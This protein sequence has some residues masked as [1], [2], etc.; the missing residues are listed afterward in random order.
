MKCSFVFARQIL[1]SLFLNSIRASVEA[2]KQRGQ[3]RIDPISVFI[4]KS[5]IELSIKISDMGGGI[6]RGEDVF[7]YQRPHGHGPEEPKEGLRLAAARKHARYL[8]G[9]LSLASMTGLATDALLHL[10]TDTD[11]AREHF[12]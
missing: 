10:R 8:G 12:P 9:D 11:L 1:H 4:V 6:E 2:A 5:P 3:H 7:K